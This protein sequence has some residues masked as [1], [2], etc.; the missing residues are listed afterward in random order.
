MPI[1]KLIDLLVKMGAVNCNCKN[2]DDVKNIDGKDDQE[3]KTG[4]KAC[5]VNYSQNSSSSIFDNNSK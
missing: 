4:V 2:D 1:E 3:I 5:K